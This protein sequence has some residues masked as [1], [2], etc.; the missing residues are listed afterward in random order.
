MLRNLLYIAHKDETAWRVALLSDLAHEDRNE[1]EFLGRFARHE[2]QERARK[3]DMVERH[4][5]HAELA[6]QRLREHRFGHELQLDEKLPD[7]PSIAAAL[8]LEDLLELRLGDDFGLDQELADSL[9]RH[10]SEW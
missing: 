9:C 5:R 3:V 10:G 2:V 7:L 8:Q 4:P 6:T 1:R